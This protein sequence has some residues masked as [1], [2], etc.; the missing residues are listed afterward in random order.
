[1]FSR[2]FRKHGVPLATYL[3]ICKKGNTVDIEGMGTVQKGVP[4]ECSRGKTGRVWCHPACSGHH[5]KQ[6]RARVLPREFTYVPSI[7]ITPRVEIVPRTCE[8]KQS[9]KEGSQEKGT[10]VQLKCQ[11]APP[12]ETHLVRKEGS[13]SCWNPFPMDS[14]HDEGGGEKKKTSILIFKK[15]PTV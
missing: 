1:M 12:G 9:E 13:L 4:H 6:T 5:C 2:P 14:W 11:P 8:G 10:W 15:M 7:L 3:R